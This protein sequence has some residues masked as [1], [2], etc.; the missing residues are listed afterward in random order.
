MFLSRIGLLILIII[1]FS[2]SF[3][4]FGSLKGFITSEGKPVP[5]ANVFIEKLKSGTNADE[6]GNYM[7]REITAGKYEVS[8]SFIGYEKT[9]QSLNIISDKTT[10]ANFELTENA[11]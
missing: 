2:D 9:T 10:T 5:F 6:N 7:I 3:A 4:Q 1:G 8:I 11:S